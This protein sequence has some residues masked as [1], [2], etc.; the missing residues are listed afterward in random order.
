M[1]RDHKDQCGNGEGEGR[2][3]RNRLGRGGRKKGGGR[4][5]LAKVNVMTEVY[6]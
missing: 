6:Q 3:E 2:K 5:V 4:T 1:E